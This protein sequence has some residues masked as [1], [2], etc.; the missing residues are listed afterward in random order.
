MILLLGGSLVAVLALAGIAWWLGLGR[1]DPITQER[2]RA[3]AEA[4]L[5][6]FRA[7][8][9]HVAADG[10]SALVLGAAREAALVKASGVEVAVRRV[11]WPLDWRQDGEA[12]IIESGEAMFGAVRLTLADAERRQLL[13]TL[14]AA[15][16]AVS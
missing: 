8:A 10:R 11:R 15:P 5:L 2:A 7:A 16:V 3:A 4:R 9:A 1:P 13:T 14:S 6:N 12:I